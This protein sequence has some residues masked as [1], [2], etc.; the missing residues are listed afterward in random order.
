MK[1]DAGW[2]AFVGM[3]SHPGVVTGAAVKEVG[4]PGL[5][6]CNVFYL[7]ETPYE[8]MSVNPFGQQ[9]P[10][11]GTTT[12]EAE[13]GVV[14]I[15]D[16]STSDMSGLIAPILAQLGAL[17][18]DQAAQ[19]KQALDASPIR[20]LGLQDAALGADGWPVRWTTQET[21]EMQDGNKR[22]NTWEGTRI[23]P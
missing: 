16:H 8:A 12:V 4:A 22:V 19:L 2:D 1:D 23:T 14:S 11:T 18:P 6:S 9:V 15:V 13:G 20:T 21:F 3:A 17:P 5:I 10:V 7:G